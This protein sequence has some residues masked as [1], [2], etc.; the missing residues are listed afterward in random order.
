MCLCYTHFLD[1]EYGTRISAHG[2]WNPGSCGGEFRPSP[3]TGLPPSP[4]APA[5]RVQTGRGLFTSPDERARGGPQ[6]QHSFSSQPKKNEIQAFDG[7]SKDRGRGGLSERAG[8]DL[9]PGPGGPHPLPQ[10]PP[11]M[12]PPP[13]PVDVITRRND[14]SPR[15]ALLLVI[16]VSKLEAARCVLSPRTWRLAVSPRA[17]NFQRRGALWVRL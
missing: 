17:G 6:P 7:R 10:R 15:R 4:S 5:Q 11:G 14:I 3:G 16:R 1:H 9:R 13:P 2:R 12:H 8:I